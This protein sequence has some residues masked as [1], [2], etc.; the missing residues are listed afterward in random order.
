MWNLF[1]CKCFLCEECC[2]NNGNDIIFERETK[3]EI[4]ATS[5]DYT[6][7]HKETKN[8]K[9]GSKEEKSVTVKGNIYKEKNNINL[10]LSD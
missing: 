4:N 2:G 5:G 3:K 9:N 10:F 6:L 7:S 8:Y 1:Q